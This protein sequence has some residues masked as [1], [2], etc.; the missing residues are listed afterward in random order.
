VEQ[1]APVKVKEAPGK[2]T[3]RHALKSIGVTGATAG[4][5]EGD[6]VA[7]VNPNPQEI[8]NPGSA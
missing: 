4:G 5:C 3:S 6:L 2:L 7:T 1:V 8:S